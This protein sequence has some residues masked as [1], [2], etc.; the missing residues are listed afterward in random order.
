M[1]MQP[2]KNRFFAFL[3]GPLYLF[4]RRLVQLGVLASLPYGVCLLL[5][6]KFRALE[7]PITFALIAYQ[8]FLVYPEKWQHKLAP[9]FFEPSKMS[10]SAS[11]LVGLIVLH[12]ML[13][14]VFYRGFIFYKHVLEM[15]ETAGALE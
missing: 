5:A 1:I 13:A 10:K 14:P 3:F 11:L 7:D 15:L 9:E 6:F 2:P 12:L 8:I 4:D